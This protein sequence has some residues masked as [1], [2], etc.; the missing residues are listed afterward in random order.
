[1]GHHEQINNKIKNLDDLLSA[2]EQDRKQ[3]RKI[4]FTNGCF[5]ILH[6]GHA[7][8]LAKAAEKGDIL[9]VAVNTDASVKKLGKAANR[10]IQDQEARA[11]LLAA[12]ESVS[13]VILFDEDTPL[14]LIDRILPDVL[15]KGSD[16]LPKNIV[17]YDAVMSH[18]GS[19]ETIDFIPGFSTTAIEQKIRGNGEK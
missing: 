17:G 6:K 15:V 2:L 9:V 11:W 10:P 5:D 18:G 1:M 7:D 12:L 16:Y 8:Y 3:G 19:V 14:V 4:V 13:Y